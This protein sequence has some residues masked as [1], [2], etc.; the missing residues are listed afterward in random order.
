IVRQRRI[1]RG[2][3][4]LASAEVK[5]QIDTKTDDRLD[6]CMYQIREAN[7]MIEEFMLVANVSVAEQILKHFPPCSLLRHHPTLTREMVEPLLRT[8]TTVGLNLDVSS[9]KALANSLDQAVGDDP[10]FN[11]Q[12]RIMATRCMT[13]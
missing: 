9:S 5:F 3:L 6:I 2:A 11:K 13:R 8:G 4:T 1:E 12:I 7:Q 10:Y